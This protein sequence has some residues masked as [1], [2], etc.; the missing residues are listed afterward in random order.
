VPKLK[1][2]VDNEKIVSVRER[3]EQHR[4]NPGASCHK[5]MDP[6]G[7]ALENFNAVGEWRLRDGGLPIDTTGEMY[8]GSRLDGPA[9]VRQ[10][11]LNHSDLFIRKFGES[12]LAYAVGR[13]LDHQ[14]MPAVRAIA[15]DAAKADNRFS[16]F[17]LGIVKSPAFQ[18]R[19][20]ASSTV[21]A[22]GRR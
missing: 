5:I 17:V 1:E 4:A 12:F 15:R 21:D 6:I 20:V 13:V 2:S 16:S 22:A 14:D 8:D 9:S 18:M 3:M 7:M 19:T 10:A 11:V